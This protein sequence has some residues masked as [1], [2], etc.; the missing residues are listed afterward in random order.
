MCEPTT[1]AMVAIGSSIVA[2]G[3]AAYGQHQQGKVAEK[4]GRNN[5]IMAEY[6]AQ[7]ARLRGEDQAQMA[8]RRGDAIKGAQRARLAASGLDLSVGT[9]G[10][11]QDQTDFFSQGDQNTARVNADRDAWSMRTSGQQASAQ[12]N[13]AAQQGNLAAFGTTLGTAGQV[14]GKWYDMNRPP[15]KAAGGY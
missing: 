9:A 2:G 5:Q 3:A 15:P 14:A 11:L 13:A 6:A 10:E 12:G 7:D 8:R 4:V 1:L